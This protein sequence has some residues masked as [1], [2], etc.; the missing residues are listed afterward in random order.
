MLRVSELERTPVLSLLGPRGTA[1]RRARADPERRQAGKAKTLHWL[2]RVTSRFPRESDA[3]TGPGRSA[4]RNF[5][6]HS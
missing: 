5:Y 2:G 6:R 1:S 4:K 3:M